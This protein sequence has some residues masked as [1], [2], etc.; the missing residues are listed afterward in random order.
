MEPLRSSLTPFRLFSAKKKPGSAIVRARLF[1][2]SS[3]SPSSEKGENL[4]CQMV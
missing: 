2:G 3:T 1:L 4:N